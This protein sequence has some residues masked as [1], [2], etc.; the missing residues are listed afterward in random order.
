[1]SKSIIIIGAGIAGLAA[2]CYG[3][4]NGYRTQIFELHDKPGGLCTS[5]KRKGYTFDG[6]IHWLVGTKPGSGFNRIWRE[7]GAV[8]GRQIVDHDE[9][10]RV[11]GE[12]DKSFILYTNIDRLE[13][14]MKSLAPADAKVIEELCQAT[15]R[16]SRLDEVMDPSGSSGLLEKIKSGLKMLPL[17]PTMVKYSKVSIQ[18]FAK[19]FSD[20][21]MRRAF[22]APFGLPDFPL[23]AFLMTLAWMHQRDAG[24][25]I[26]GSLEFAQ[27]IERR[28]LELGG[29]IHYKARV[30][31]ILVEANSS[32]R[33]DRAVGVRLADG[34]EH[35]ADAGDEVSAIISAA[36]GHAT[37][38]DMLEGEYADDKI[39]G[40]Y[41]ELP[42][43]QP[44]IQISL[45]VERDLSAEPHTVIYPLDEPITIGGAKRESLSIRHF[46]YDPS[47]AP[48]GKS[49]ITIMFPSNYEYW[50]KLHEDRERYDAEKKE[51]AITVI[52]QLEKRFPGIAGQVEAV[53]VA[54]PMTYERYTGNWQ[55]SM[56]GWM[57]TTETMQLTRGRGMAKTLPG[58]KNFYMAGQWVEPG[59]GLP[60]AA[61]SGRGVI[62]TICKQNGK[63]FET[64]VP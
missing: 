53:D 25:P 4:M 18:D 42:I 35:R 24:Y 52:E 56:E 34:A 21:F 6:C 32:G 10:M 5:W 51:I 62:E 7:L 46:C 29:E 36:D 61:R 38:F 23:I 57:I 64:Q 41:D 13:Q 9:F 37:I 30:E 11:E 55:G 59:G 20:P 63:P 60:P 22:V 15:R 19:R 39:R 40:Y 3:Q 28:Y 1:M 2:G 49:A 44:I 43:F 54:T 50:K 58:L 26:G 16:I 31:K 33:G 8:Q 47:M 17:I 45:G 14:H 48:A 12:G 27:A